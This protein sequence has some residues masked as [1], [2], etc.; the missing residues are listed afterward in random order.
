MIYQLLKVLYDGAPTETP[1]GLSCKMQILITAQGET[2]EEFAARKNV[3]VIVPYNTPCTSIGDS[4]T[5]IKNTVLQHCINYVNE[6]FN[7]NQL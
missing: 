1:D 7:T 4:I 5:A 3:T 6:N 2:N